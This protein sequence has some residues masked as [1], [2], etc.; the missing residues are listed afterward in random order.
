[1]RSLAFLILLLFAPLAQ[2]QT[3]DAGVAR[4]D[5]VRQIERAATDLGALTGFPVI[6]QPILDAFARVPRHQFVPPPLIDY[7]YRDTPLPLGHGQNLTQPFLL[8]LMT[9]AL[10]LKPGE[11]VF[12]TGTD[13]GYQAAILAE[14]GMQVFSVEIIEPLLDE[15]RK[16][17]PAA[18][19]PKVSLKLG[20][21][22]YGWAEQGPYDAMLIKESAIDIPGVLWQQLKPGG[23]M[24]IPLGSPD[25]GQMLTLCI[26]QPNGRSQRIPLMPVRFAPFQGGSRI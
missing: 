14:M 4:R 18:G 13:T 16:L 11:R 10:A 21:G 9:Q 2:A 5:M 12:E 24:V 19:Y 7:A 6:D 26:K 23:R 15:A 25:N 17:L 3:P 20:D 22:Y 8:A 1:M